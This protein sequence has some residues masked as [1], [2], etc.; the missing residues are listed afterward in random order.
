[1]E[2][3]KKRTYLNPDG[4]IHGENL[5]RRRP[6][7]WTRAGSWWTN[8]VV[9]R[10]WRRLVVCLGRH[11]ARSEDSDSDDDKVTRVPLNSEKG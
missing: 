1:M 2:K 3:L 7:A 11:G 4:L 8:C 10:H 6:M 5:S 9:Q